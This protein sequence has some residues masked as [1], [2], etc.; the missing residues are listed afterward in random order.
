[1]GFSYLGIDPDEAAIVRARDVSG[2]EHA[3]FALAD[4]AEA[5]NFVKANDIAVLNGVCHHLSEAVFSDVLQSLRIC[6][7]IFV[8]DHQLDSLTS[9]LNR[10]LQKHDKGKH[11]RQSELFAAL[12][13]YQR[14]YHEVFPIPA[15]IAPVWRYFCSYYVPENAPL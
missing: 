1:M 6:R 14:V 5:S 8:L 11:V 10:L 4:A 9:P 2:F 13:G 15:H 3:S 7:G 12:P